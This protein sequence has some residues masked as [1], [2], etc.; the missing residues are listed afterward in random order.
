MQLKEND[1]DQL[2]L[3]LEGPSVRRAD[4]PIYPGTKITYI[5][6]THPQLKS[7]GGDSTVVWR[8]QEFFNDENSA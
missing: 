7:I 8:T 4:I 5:F 6:A 3:E 1:S 2:D